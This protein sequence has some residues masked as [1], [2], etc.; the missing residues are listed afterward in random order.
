MST[1]FNDI[2][3]LL[4]AVG[5]S[6]LAGIVGALFTTPA[7]SVWYKGLIKS[8]L[9]PPAWVFGPVWTIL[10]LLMGIAAFFVWRK[11]MR[12]KGVQNALILFCI[13]L[14]LNTIWSVIFF[15]F[16]NPGVA[17]LELILL[18]CTILFTMVLFSRVSQ[19]AVW[20]LL[21]YILW[22]TFAG[23]LNYIIWIYN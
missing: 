8:G 6:E 7:I 15:G 20:L 17:F 18:W 12:H 1:R 4:V 22:V 10:F 14:V 19:L 2:L 21:P 13:Q 16:H 3:K 23:Y 5:V 9:T 11:G